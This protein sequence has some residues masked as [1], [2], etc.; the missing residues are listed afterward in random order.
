[1]K[2]WN[3][4]EQYLGPMNETGTRQSFERCVGVWVGG[5]CVLVEGWGRWIDGR[6]HHISE[7]IAVL[8]GW[9]DITKKWTESVH[10]ASRAR[11]VT[12]GRREIAHARGPQATEQTRKGRL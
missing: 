12:H 4:E 8:L 5:R 2:I 9:N 10:G 7:L 3:V 6:V 11:P 1:M